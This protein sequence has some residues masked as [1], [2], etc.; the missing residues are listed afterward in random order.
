VDLCCCPVVGGSRPADRLLHQGVEL[1]TDPGDDL[2]HG[3]GL[4]HSIS[5]SRPEL[6]ATGSPRVTA[7]RHRS[8][9]ALLIWGYTDGASGCAGMNPVINP[10]ARRPLKARAIAV[11]AKTGSAGADVWMLWAPLSEARSCVRG[12]PICPPI[13]RHPTPERPRH[14]RPRRQAGGFSG[15]RSTRVRRRLGQGER[16]C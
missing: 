3:E 10:R 5:Q 13:R 2:G 12:A 1:G 4:G 14:R 11:P 8:R 7:A 9:V 15:R 6:M 16:R